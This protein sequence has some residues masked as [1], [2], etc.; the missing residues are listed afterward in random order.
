MLERIR[1]RTAEEE[2][3]DLVCADVFDDPELRLAFDALHDH[4][5]AEFLGE[6]D[7]RAHHC[8]CLGMRCDLLHKHAVD[9]ESVEWQFL[10]IDRKSTRLNSSHLGIS[11]A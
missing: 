5:H 6:L 8:S 10:D 4:L 11:Y 9:L 2:S 7:E 1:R 3:L